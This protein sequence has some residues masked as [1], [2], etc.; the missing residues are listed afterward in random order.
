MP[1]KTLYFDSF[2]GYT[3]SAVTENGKVTEFSFEK[4]V[5]S[6]AVGNIYKGVVECVLP[7]MQAAFVNCGLER[8]CFLSAEDA[9]PDSEKYEGGAETDFAMPDVKVGDEIIV[10]VV[11]LPVGKKGAKVTTHL[12]LVGNY[13]IYLPTSPFIGVSRKIADD[14]LRRNLAYSVKKIKTDAEGLVVRTSAPYAKHDSLKKE[15]IYLKNLYAELAEKGGASSVGQ[16]LYTDVSL[17]VRVMRDVLCKDVDKLVVGSVKLKEYLDKLMSLNPTSARRPVVLHNTGRDMMDELGIS[18]QILSILSPKVPLDNGGY[19]VIERT[20]ALTVIDVNTGKFTGDYNL[21]QTVYHTNILAAREIARQVRLRNIGGIVVVD[22]IDMN[23]QA[24]GKAL[25]EEL[26]RRLKTD[27]AKCTVAPMSQ[28]GLVEF[29]RKRTGANPL[30]FMVKPC[31]YCKNAGYTL[32][33]QYIIFG[34][35]AK[36]LYLLS[37]GAE[38]IRID[39]NTEVLNK[40]LNSNELLEDFK[41]ISKG[42]EVCAVPHRTYH[43]EQINFRTGIFE[44]PENAVKLS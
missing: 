41:N 39:L 22:F 25:V 31:K 34:L 23:N 16:L 38:K 4:N 5:K 10:Q 24:H 20:E 17:P 9:L 6:C 35:R 1:K 13:L 28:F 42:A 19:L 3:V 11:K 21:E 12:S 40:L 33:E 18:A 14:E 15:Y 43:E 30:S 2:C 37:E 36:L 8:N 27:K 44:T 7:G 32:T 29:T 26:E